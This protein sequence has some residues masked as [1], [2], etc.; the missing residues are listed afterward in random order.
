MSVFVKD[1]PEGTFAYISAL[2]SHYLCVWGFLNMQ[3]KNAILGLKYKNV[4][5]W[6]LYEEGKGMI[7]E[8]EEKNG[9]LMTI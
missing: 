4:L 8:N 9:D 5:F 2:F 6:D 3:S 7:E 1:T